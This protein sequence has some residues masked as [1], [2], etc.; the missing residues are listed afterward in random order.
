MHGRVIQPSTRDECPCLDDDA[1][2]KNLNKARPPCNMHGRIVTCMAKCPTIGPC[3]C[4]SLLPV[5]YAPK[6][7]HEHTYTVIRHHVHPKRHPCGRSRHAKRWNERMVPR[8]CASPGRRSILEEQHC[9]EPKTH[10]PRLSHR[11]V[12]WLC[13]RAP[14]CEQGSLQTRACVLLA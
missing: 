9:R 4:V 5:A 1:W 2:I 6:K 11:H 12:M 8:V 3:R 10:A 14:V 13:Q 7:V